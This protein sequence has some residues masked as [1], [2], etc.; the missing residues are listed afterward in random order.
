MAKR[1]G[2]IGKQNVVLL[3]RATKAIGKKGKIVVQSLKTGDTAIVKRS[4]VKSVTSRFP[5][6]NR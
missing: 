2:K 4:K 3:D 6:K 5:K 1:F